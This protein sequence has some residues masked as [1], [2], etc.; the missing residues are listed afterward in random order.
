MDGSGDIAGADAVAVPV[1]P[2][3]RKGCG[4]GRPKGKAK[5]RP[6]IDIDDQI[7]GANRV[8]TMMKKLASAAKSMQKNGKMVKQRLMKKAGKLSAGDLERIA[9]LKRCGLFTGN[10]EGD[11]PD[12]AVPAPDL[13]IQV[14]QAWS[15]INMK[16]K[17]VMGK[18]PGADLMFGPRSGCDLMSQPSGS[19]SSSSVLGVA[20]ACPLGGVVVPARRLPPVP[21]SRALLTSSEAA[22]P[23]AASASGLPGSACGDASDE[24]V[25]DEDALSDT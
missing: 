4:K 24:A 2:G 1:V 15:M 8:A 13:D 17:D 7:E 5:A 14:S 6:R 12:V 9:V 16:M 11:V 10:V 22:V 3:V 20:P 21:G 23:G 19:S 18:M 25:E